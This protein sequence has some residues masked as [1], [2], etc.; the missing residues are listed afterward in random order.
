MPYAASVSTST[1]NWDAYFNMPHTAGFPFCRAS[2]EGLIRKDRPVHVSLHSQKNL[3]DDKGPGFTI[4]SRLDFAGIGI[5]RILDRLRERV[6]DAT[7][8]S[9]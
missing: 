8:L 9:P 7:P 1:G 5:D 6:S 3:I 4:V 2:K